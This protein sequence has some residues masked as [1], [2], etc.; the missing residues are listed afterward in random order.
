VAGGRIPAA[1]QE[2]ESESLQ[3]F[4]TTLEFSLEF[5][6]RRIRLASGLQPPVSGL[7]RTCPTQPPFSN[8]NLNETEFGVRRFI[9][10]L[11]SPGTRQPGSH[12]RHRRSE[13]PVTGTKLSKNKMNRRASEITDCGWR[14]SHQSDSRSQ[15][16]LSFTVFCIPAAPVLKFEL[17][18]L[19]SAARIVRICPTE[20][21]LS[22]WNLQETEFRVRRF[23]SALVSAGACQPRFF[24]APAL[25]FSNLNFPD[26]S[27]GTPDFKLKSTFRPSVFPPASRQPVRRSWKTGGWRQNS[28]GKSG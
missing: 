16:S 22:N 8:W 23:V 1:V 28:C 18:N 6:F 20:P 17:P 7:S 19:K 4:D 2:A 21:P 27:D 9:S 24:F 13:H 14:R 11:V 3:L 26:V 15:D 10:A 12:D 25:K 5:V